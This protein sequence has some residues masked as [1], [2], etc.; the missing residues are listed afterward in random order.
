MASAPQQGVEEVVSNLLENLR[1]SMALNHQNQP[2][3]LPDSIALRDGPLR[4]HYEV[5]GDV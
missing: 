4:M 2:E 3:V 1:A 5:Q